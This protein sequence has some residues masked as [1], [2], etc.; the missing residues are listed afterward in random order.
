[1]P[2]ERL[3][4]SAWASVKGPGEPRAL[5]LWLLQAGFR[6]LV[7]APGPRHVDWSAV[8]RA[9]D[10]LP[11]S[12]RAVRA[13]GIQGSRGQ[14]LA[15][16]K[17]GELVDARRMV[18][19]AVGLARRFGTG[20]VLL[21]PG[22]VPLAGEA[23]ALDDLGDPALRPGDPIIAPLMARRRVGVESALDRVCRC[24]HSLG[25]AWP[26]MTFCL[27]LGRNLTS[28]A[29]RRSLAAI[30]E[31]LK[32]TR[33]GYWHDAALAARR[34]ALLGEG[35]GEL[36]ES[37][38]NLLAG[39]TLSDASAEGIYLPPG[40]GGVDCRLLGSYVLRSGPPLPEVVE[41]EPSVDSSELPGIRAFLEKFGL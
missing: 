36:L 38:S 11:V 1:M 28:L 31:D 27:T 13:T 41:L 37:F 5:L 17:E 3:L 18:A 40:S 16:A 39:L 29:D 20:L 35:Q 21:E 19:D 6:G 32:S 14:G 10:D 9:A 26:D 12:F 23:P 8:L 34:Q 24:L 7:P 30:F 22:S 2:V 4:G 33:L 25:K 15:S